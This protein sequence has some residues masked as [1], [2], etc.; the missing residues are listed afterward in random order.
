MCSVRE[1]SVKMSCFWVQKN[2]QRN[3]ISDVSFG[4]EYS[5]IR[6]FEYSNITKESP[7]CKNLIDSSPFFQK[8]PGQICLSFLT[9]DE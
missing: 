1:K 4:T 7:T 5:N 6:I 8:E 2:I 3:I 9:S